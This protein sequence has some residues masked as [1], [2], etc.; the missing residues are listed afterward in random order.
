MSKLTGIA[1]C[2]L[3]LFLL[4][5]ASCARSGSGSV[6]APLPA[7]GVQDVADLP[8]PLLPAPAGL[9]AGNPRQ[10]SAAGTLALDGAAFDS[11]LPASLVAADVIDLQY[12]PDYDPGNGG[13]SPAYAIF[14]FNL[15][16][17]A[18]EPELRLIWTTPPAEGT[19]W[20]GLANFGTNRWDWQAAP[21]DGSP[22]DLGNLQFY[23][24][25]LSSHLYI[26]VLLTG[27]QPASLYRVRLG[28]PFVEG[29]APLPALSSGIGSFTAQPQQAGY[30]VPGS[31][32]LFDYDWDGDGSFEETDRAENDP[33]EHIYSGGDSSGILRYHNDEGYDDQLAFDVHVLDSWDVSEI[34]GELDVVEIEKPRLAVV[35]GNLGLLYR[36][37]TV[38]GNTYNMLYRNIDPA[39]QDWGSETEISAAG[40]PANLT[41]L[42]EVDGTP[43]FCFVTTEDVWFARSSTALGDDW[44]GPVKCETVPVLNGLL[45]ECNMALINDNP[46]WV[47]RVQAS[48]EVW[49]ERAVDSSGTDWNGGM[50]FVQNGASNKEITLGEVGGLPAVTYSTGLGYRMIQADTEDGKSNWLTEVL[51]ITCKAPYAVDFGNIGGYPSLLVSFNLD[52]TYEFPAVQQPANTDGSGGW[53]SSFLGPQV[54]GTYYG[55]FCDLTA[56]DPKWGYGGM[57]AFLQSSGNDL[58][59]CFFSTQPTYTESYFS[60]QIDNGL[61]DCQ[62][63]MFGDTPVVAFT[64]DTKT[65][66]IAVLH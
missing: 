54:A 33:P 15:D 62:A 11:G 30:G 29:E 35:Q 46:A 32:G 4:A 24:N 27:T 53:N 58:G 65:L 12:S 43:A 13:L 61:T 23:K 31:V 57:A 22:L 42:L 55:D 66:Q 44:I 26:A 9:K 3:S 2:S 17:S 52:D 7:A 60:V 5:L 64:T 18:P 14:N 59:V 21:V 40:F 38:A 37:R 48:G 51:N 1:L 8:V 47:V 28:Q 6:Y 16:G 41:D 36:Q 25:A 45:S 50:G 56:V 20:L 39:S 34:D 63:V 19:A 49:Y 10:A